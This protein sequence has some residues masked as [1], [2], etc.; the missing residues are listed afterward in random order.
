M[1]SKFQWVG[2]QKSNV[3]VLSY[4]NSIRLGNVAEDLRIRTG[5][6]LKIQ[7]DKPIRDFEVQLE[8]HNIVCLILDTE[9][10]IYRA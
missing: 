3:F 10:S 2:K 8:G 1:I 7:I 5:S 6:R 9:G 4:G